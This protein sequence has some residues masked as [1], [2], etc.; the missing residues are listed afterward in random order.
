MESAIVPSN[1]NRIL[2][3]AQL[4]ANLK[5]NTSDK[6]RI[7]KR[8]MSQMVKHGKT[9][10][11]LKDTYPTAFKIIDQYFK[12]RASIILSNEVLVRRKQCTIHWIHHDH[13]TFTTFKEVVLFGL[14]KD[15]DVLLLKESDMRP[16]CGQAVVLFCVGRSWTTSSLYQIS[17]VALSDVYPDCEHLWI[18]SVDIPILEENIQRQLEKIIDLVEDFVYYKHY[19]DVLHF[20]SKEALISHVVSAEELENSGE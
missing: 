9:I 2:T 3:E 1:S 12:G 7:L 14:Y 15:D 16:Y 6:A 5:G 13:M 19:I 18:A 11:F 4:F 8:Y 17:Q 10:P 20:S